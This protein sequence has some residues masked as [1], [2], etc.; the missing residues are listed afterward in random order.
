[1]AAAVVVVVVVDA[2]AVVVVVA[3][4]D[5]VVGGDDDG[6]GGEIS[7]RF[8]SC[9]DLGDFLRRMRFWLRVTGVMRHI[10]CLVGTFWTCKINIYQ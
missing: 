5:A 9:S 6:D 8:V 1:M 10:L 2:A 3:A 4:V 7:A